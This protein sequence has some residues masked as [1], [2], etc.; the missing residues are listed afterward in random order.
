MN[1]YEFNLIFSYFK[2]YISIIQ[3]LFE[4]AGHQAMVIIMKQRNISQLP[5]A[6]CTQCTLMQSTHLRFKSS[7]VS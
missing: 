7:D 4:K 6:K 5:L 2:S 1:K 3:Y